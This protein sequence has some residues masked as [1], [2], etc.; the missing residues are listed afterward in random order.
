M[1]SNTKIIKLLDGDKA[2]FNKE[3]A[4]GLLGSC[5]HVEII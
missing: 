3:L 5:S 2:S 4:Y 1:A